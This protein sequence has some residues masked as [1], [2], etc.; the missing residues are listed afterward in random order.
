MAYIGGNKAGDD[1]SGASEKLSGGK[2]AVIG[3]NKI[4][5]I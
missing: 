4:K 5:I 2:Y 1:V 3:N